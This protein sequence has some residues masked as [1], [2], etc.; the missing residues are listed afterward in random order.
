MAELVFEIV[1]RRRELGVPSIHHTVGVGGNLYFP[2]GYGVTEVFRSYYWVPEG[3][4]SPKKKSKRER[5]GEFVELSPGSS[6]NRTAH[7][8]TDATRQKNTKGGNVNPSRW[9]NLNLEALGRVQRSFVGKQTEQKKMCSQPR[10]SRYNC[11]PIFGAQTPQNQR[12]LE[13][14]EG[15]SRVGSLKESKVPES[16]QKSERS[17]WM[18]E[19]KVSLSAS[20]VVQ[21]QDDKEEEL[22]KLGRNDDDHYLFYFTN[23][24]VLL[25][26]N[27]TVFPSPKTV[28]FKYITRS[29]CIPCTPREADD[30][31]LSRQTPE[32]YGAYI[33]WIPNGLTVSLGNGRD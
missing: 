12:I 20:I 7:R 33:H 32:F 17:A 14:D 26:L 4:K 25:Y 28:A 1:G 21:R 27:V 30:T 24:R 8:K 5:K 11:Q 13:E 22:A 2:P 19:G 16:A 3:V 6:G 31:R 23:F 29:R 18:V 15:G 10:R 9:K